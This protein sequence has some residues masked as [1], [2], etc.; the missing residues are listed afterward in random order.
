MP[1]CSR[2]RTAVH[3]QDDGGS[4]AM[5]TRRRTY[6]RQMVVRTA[7]PS[8]TIGMA[9]ALALMYWWGVTNS[10]VCNWRKVL[11]VEGR[12][13]TPGSQRL[14]QA[15]A[16]RGAE[17]M[18]AHTFTERARGKATERRGPGPGPAPEDGLPWAA[19]DG[20]GPGLAEDVAR[21]RGGPAAGKDGNRGAGDADQE[22]HS[23]YNPEYNQTCRRD[24]TRCHN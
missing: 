19:L 10:T 23:R 12:A 24:V 18:Q 2:A 7:W 14:I 22:G 17:A 1:H 16:E 13:G 5:P 8:W 11:G 9:S 20:R 15:A 6:P 21:C 3:P 4:F